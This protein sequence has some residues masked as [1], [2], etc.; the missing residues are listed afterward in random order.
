[1]TRAEQLK[2]GLKVELDFEEFSEFTGMIFGE[3]EV[4]SFLKEY[5]KEL[6]DADLYDEIEEDTGYIDA[7]GDT[8]KK[9][10]AFLEKNP[11][12]H[13]VTQCITGDTEIWDNKMRRLDRMNYVLAVGNSCEY[14]FIAEE[15]E[16]EEE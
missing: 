16:D 5:E 9:V 11:G 4:E 10:K 14:I 8:E 15:R 7:N 12:F 1:M 2:K 6:K 3:E 13:V